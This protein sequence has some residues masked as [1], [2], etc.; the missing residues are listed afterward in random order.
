VI[1]EFI[2]T[3]AKQGFVLAKTGQSPRG[4]DVRHGLSIN[5][6]SH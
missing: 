2:H 1:G 5:P 4:V 3:V 6:K